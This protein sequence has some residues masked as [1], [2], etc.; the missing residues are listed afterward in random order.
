VVEPDLI[1]EMDEKMLN[2]KY[3]LKASQDRKKRYD[4]KGI[5]QR[6]FKVGDHVF[7]KVKSNRSSM[8]F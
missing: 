7:L 3:N 4:Y 8:K 5:T 6:E 2:I 1:K